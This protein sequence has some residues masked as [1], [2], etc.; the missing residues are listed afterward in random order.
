MPSGLATLDKAQCSRVSARTG[1]FALVKQVV[2]LVVRVGRAA[3]FVFLLAPLQVN[4][5]VLAQICGHRWHITVSCDGG[6]EGGRRAAPASRD[7][8]T[9]TILQ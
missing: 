5:W 4:V 7:F 1:R 8:A 9:A 2:S 6:M 3:R